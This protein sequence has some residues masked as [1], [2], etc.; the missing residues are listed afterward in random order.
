MKMQD[1]NGV[2]DTNKW[3]WGRAPLHEDSVRF[4][5]LRDYAQARNTCASVPAGLFR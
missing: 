5:P 1:A 4:T 2:H 3:L